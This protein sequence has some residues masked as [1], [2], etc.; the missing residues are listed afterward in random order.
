M[1]RVG[2]RTTTAARWFEPSIRVVA[3]DSTWFDQYYERGARGARWL[4]VSPLC[5]ALDTG[6]TARLAGT[7]L[8]LDTRAGELVVFQSPDLDAGPMLVLAPHPDDAEIAAFGLYRAHRSFVVTLTAG[9]YEGRGLEHLAPDARARTELRGRLR[10]W[11][12]AAVPLWGGVPPD[13]VANLGYLNGALEDMHARPDALVGQ[14]R[15]GTRA[16]RAYRKQIA[17]PLLADREPD[18]TWSSLIEDLSQ[19]LRTVRPA[20]IVAPHPL[21]DRSAD[22]RYTTVAVLEALARVGESESLLLL[23]TNHAYGSEYYPFGPADGWVG[24]PPVPDDLT[25]PAVFSF[26]LSE[27]ALLDKLFALDGM[28]DLR[29]APRRHVGEATRRELATA[30]RLA[31][32][33]WADPHDYYS[34]YRRAAR[35]NEVFFPVDRDERQRLQ[36]DLRRWGPS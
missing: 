16:V 34:Y 19:L 10:V 32:E 26:P 15:G 4:N 8:A 22:H 11:D 14:D 29:P 36:D 2:I 25:I 1:L 6:M 13:R 27:E 7:H 17:S 9:D 5:D 30:R 21:L 20:T 28:H 23:Y 12:S 18:S 33:F 35:P 24:L 31:R 3:N